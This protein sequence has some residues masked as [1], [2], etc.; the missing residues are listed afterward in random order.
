MVTSLEAQLILQYL[1]LIS[2]CGWFGSASCIVPDNSHSVFLFS[3][4]GEPRPPSSLG[5]KEKTQTL[6]HLVERTD[7]SSGKTWSLY[8]LLLQ[9]LS[10]QDSFRHGAHRAKVG[11]RHPKARRSTASTG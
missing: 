3:P 11:W 6:S 7:F 8:G 10:S 9:D 5:Q 1:S 2:M 4:L